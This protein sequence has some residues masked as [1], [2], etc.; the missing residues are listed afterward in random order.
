[1]ATVLSLYIGGDISFFGPG[2]NSSSYLAFLYNSVGYVSGN[3]LVAVAFT[4]VSIL[5]YFFINL[6]TFIKRKGVK[7]ND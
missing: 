7:E 2:F 4:L 6:P 5:I 1:M 3:L